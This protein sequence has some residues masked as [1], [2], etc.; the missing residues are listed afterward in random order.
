MTTLTS[1]F[2]DITKQLQQLSIWRPNERNPLLELERWREDAHQ[3]IEQ[4]YNKKRY[5]IG[6][7][8]EKHEREFLRQLA[9]QRLQM[10]NIQQKIPTKPVA[11]PSLRTFHEN[12]IFNELQTIEND[13]NT[14]L[15]RAEI[16]LETL[17][18]NCN[19]LVTVGLK[20]YLSGKPV[21]HCKEISFKDLPKRS[22]RRSA[23]EV[24]TAHQKW[25]QTKK[26]EENLRREYFDT[27]QQELANERQVFFRNTANQAA[28][29][30]W[31][32]QKRESG[33]FK[34]RKVD[35]RRINDSIEQDID[36][37]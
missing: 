30:R 34:K 3:T 20:T 37:S 35:E 6:Q 28:F 26:E 1:K 11:N 33:A 32:Q 14:R 17:P 8:T 4:L 5:E 12:S 9:R 36:E 15:G 7:V 23:D 31:K 13:I 29:E 10:N 16:T 24:R 19:G 27:R 18:L 25:L 21:P 2:Q 22:A